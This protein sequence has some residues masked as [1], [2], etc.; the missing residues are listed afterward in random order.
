MANLFNISEYT[1]AISILDPGVGSRILSVF[2]LKRI[3][4]LSVKKVALD[5]Y[6]SDDKIIPILKDN[7]EYAKSV[8]KGA[9]YTK[10]AAG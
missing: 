9:E 4:A 7:L 8:V 2:L 1:T 10:Q 6:E 3:A 5:C